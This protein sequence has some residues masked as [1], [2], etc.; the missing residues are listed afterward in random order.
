M[1]KPGNRVSILA[2]AGIKIDSWTY[3][4]NS[5]AGG[6]EQEVTIQDDKEKFN[7]VKMGLNSKSFRDKNYLN[8]VVSTNVTVSAKT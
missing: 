8:G 3:D 6:A 2:P 4:G 1:Q 5:Y 7:S